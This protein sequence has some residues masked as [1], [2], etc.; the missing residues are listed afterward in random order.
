MDP[1]KTEDQASNAL[2][3]RECSAPQ[4]LNCKVSNMIDKESFSF[5]QLPFL[6][7]FTVPFSGSQNTLQLRPW[8]LLTRNWCKPGQV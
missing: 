2:A 8:V 6:F 5:S 4:S 1:R 7:C 3:V